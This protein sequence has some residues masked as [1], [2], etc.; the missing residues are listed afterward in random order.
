MV[1]CLAMAGEWRN[2][3]L[4]KTNTYLADESHGEACAQRMHTAAECTCGKADAESGEAIAA[5]TNH[6]PGPWTV[7][8]FTDDDG[9][10]AACVCGEMG[11]LF[12]VT[13]TEGTEVDNCDIANLTLAAA[14]PEMLEAL[15]FVLEY[16]DRGDKDQGHIYADTL[17]PIS[18]DLTVADWIKRIVVKAERGEL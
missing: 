13:P 6:T 9:K 5:K 4:M 10:V 15:Q 17:S 11:Y 18:D 16:L 2:L 7:D 1:G 8:K 12:G 14:A 3:K